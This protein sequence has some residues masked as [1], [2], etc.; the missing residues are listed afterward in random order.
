MSLTPEKP[1]YQLR[2]TAQQEL[3][4]LEFPMAQ[5]ST[6]P[7]QVFR[8][9]GLLQGRGLREEL[10]AGHIRVGQQVIR[11]PRYKLLPGYILSWREYRITIRQDDEMKRRVLLMERMRPGGLG[12]PDQA[13]SMG[14]LPGK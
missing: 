12:N 10:K 13:K 5:W 4:E 7:V 2:H 14:Y 9:L 1:L 3:V 11:D 8:V 6:T